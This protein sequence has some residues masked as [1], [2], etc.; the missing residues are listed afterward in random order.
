MR[1]WS[2]FWKC[3]KEVSL[4]LWSDTRELRMKLGSKFI[5]LR[6][7]NQTFYVGEYVMLRDNIRLTFISAIKGGSIAKVTYCNKDKNYFSVQ[8]VHPVWSPDYHH[9][10]R[11][12]RIPELEYE[13]YKWNMKKM[14]KLW[15]I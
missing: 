2:K 12:Q 11:R 15:E 14:K 3:F 8:V 4:E 10:Y 13:V 6:Q 1:W 9:Y 7:F 5:K